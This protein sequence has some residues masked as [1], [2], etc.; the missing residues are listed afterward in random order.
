MFIKFDDE[1]ANEYTKEKLVQLATF[2]DCKALSGLNKADLIA[3]IKSAIAAKNDNQTASKPTV[4]TKPTVESTLLNHSHLE[5]LTKDELYNIA[6][7]CDLGGLSASNKPEIIVRLLDV[8]V[9]TKHL[10][11]EQL[12]QICSKLGLVNRLSLV[13]LVAEVITVA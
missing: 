13:N 3:K 12:I 1:E 6:K 8:G 2:L 4:S 9:T 5:A 7:A 10:N 11:E